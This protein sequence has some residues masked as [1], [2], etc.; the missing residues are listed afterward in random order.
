MDSENGTDNVL[1]DKRKSLRARGDDV[2][3]LVSGGTAEKGKS[4]NDS[5]DEDGQPQ[6]SWS[7]VAPK[8]ESHA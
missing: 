5:G 7:E 2:A 3:G 4:D 6:E 1:T 8:G